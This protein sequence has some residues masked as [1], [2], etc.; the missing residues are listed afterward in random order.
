MR[1]PST[2]FSI[3]PYQGMK[4][5]M[6]SYLYVFPT[7]KIVEGY[8]NTLLIDFQTNQVHYIP[9]T[10][11]TII[12][13]LTKQKEYLENLKNSDEA[14]IVDEI[15]KKGF[16]FKAS[17]N[18]KHSLI[19][20]NNSWEFPSKI[21]NSIVE[22][23]NL[24]Q[25][26][27]YGTIA[28]INALNC[29]YI[30]IRIS[31]KVLQEREILELIE[32]IDSLSFRSIELTIDY[33]Y[34]P[35]LESIASYGKIHKIF[36]YNSPRKEHINYK[37]KKILVIET[38][39]VINAKSCGHVSPSYFTTA[40]EHYFE[41]CNFNSCLNKKLGIDTSGNIK[42]CPSFSKSFGNVNT[43]NVDTIIDDADFK[44]LWHITKE[45]IDVCK[46]CEFRHI[47]TDCRAFTD[48]KRPNSR[49]SKCTYNPYI[50]K[51][52]GE[53]GYRTLQECGIRSDETG[54][55]IDHDKIAAINREL[56]GDDE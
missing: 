52:Q 40:P 34:A 56:W 17:I 1:M 37:I 3:N 44:P 7:V 30:E 18:E 2:H 15:I 28:K 48:H 29:F 21:S 20:H 38:P 13:K 27:V 16:G 49:P 9:R 8:K 22:I 26:D 50:G 11:S 43:H 10:V 53:E 46:D 36:L 6:P 12:T 32:Y 54:F 39:N 51:W 55:Y 45:Q 24:N 25:Y 47:C 41:S 19:E 4:S 42:N 5:K 23:E 14:E 31:S 33:T 35:I